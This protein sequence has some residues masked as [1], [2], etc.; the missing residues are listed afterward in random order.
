MTDIRAVFAGLGDMHTELVL[1]GR[2]L[3]GMIDE[4]TELLQIAA[5]TSS[6][7]SPRLDQACAV[8][9]DALNDELVGWVSAWSPTVPTAQARVIANLGINALLGD[10]LARSLLHNSA[11]GA[12]DEDYLAEWTAVLSA[13]IATLTA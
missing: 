12:S 7:R 11:A 13:R 4:E 8:F 5:R 3:L 2:Y 9:I 10:R 6:K 1:L